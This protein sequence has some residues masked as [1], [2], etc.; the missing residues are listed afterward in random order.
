MKNS[1]KPN[2]DMGNSK[3]EL[4]FSYFFIFIFMF[5][6]IYQDYPKKWVEFFYHRFSWKVPYNP[7]L[8]WRIQKLNSF[9]QIF[10]FSFF[11][12][13]R[14]VKNVLKNG[15]VFFLRFSW[16]LSCNLILIWR[17]QKSNSFFQ[18]FS[19]SSSFLA[20]FFSHLYQVNSAS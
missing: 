8:I 4:I 7:S 2:F 6:S 11:F 5:A 17:I 13:P 20:S 3:L 16:K 10:F 1:I 19:C 15:S 12:L 14:L 18:V 9:L